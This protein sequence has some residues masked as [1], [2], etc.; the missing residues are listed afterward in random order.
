MPDRKSGRKKVR[1]R[2]PK[3]ARLVR[4]FWHPAGITLAVTLVLIVIVGLGV[5]V[6]NYAKYSRLVD[7]KLLAGP[8]GNTSKIFAAPRLIA[9]GDTITPEEIAEHLRHCGYGDSRGNALGRFHERPDG[10]IEIFP[11][12]DSY[13]GRE[14]GVIKFARGKISAD[15]FARGQ[16]RARPISARAATDHQS[17]STATAKSGA[18]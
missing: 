9:I 4:F 7:Q 15:R 5:T 8:F 12:P 11:G 18:W 2:V 17:C 10:G 6:H 16:Y 13:F 1:V 3:N 14:A